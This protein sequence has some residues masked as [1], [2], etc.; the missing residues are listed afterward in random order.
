MADKIPFAPVGTSGST[1]STTGKTGKVAF[2][3][4][5]GVAP[6]TKPK[7]ATTPETPQIMNFAKTFF[8]AINTGGAFLEGFLNQSIKNVGDLYSGKAKISIDPVTGGVNFTGQKDPFTAGAQNATAWVRGEESKYG[9]DILKTAYEAK[10]TPVDLGKATTVD[11]P[12]LGPVSLGGLGLDI[13]L[14]P[15]NLI[16]G[17]VFTTPLKAATVGAK[18]LVKEAKLAKAGQLSEAVATKAGTKVVE[19]TAPQLLKPGASPIEQFTKKPLI[20][21]KNIRPEG[22]LA[23]RLAKTEKTIVEG[24][25]VLGKQ[26]PSILYKTVQ[27]AE[28]VPLSQAIASGLE[29]SAKAAKTVVLGELANASLSAL[30]KGERKAATVATRALINGE[31]KDLQPFEPHIAP[32]AT[33]VFDEM[34]V[35]HKFTNLDEATAWVKTQKQVGEKVNSTVGGV[36]VIDTGA[37]A[38]TPQIMARL[39]KN[40]EEAKAAQKSLTLID[41]IASKATG[42]AKN[43]VERTYSGFNDFIAGLSAGD[44][45]DYAVLEKIIKVLDPENKLVNKLEKAANTKNSYKL[46]KEALIAE[47]PQTV[48]DTQRRID[49]VN[50]NT[51]LKATG[52][53]EADTAAAYAQ[54]R[55]DGTS[56][57]SDIALSQS[58]NQAQINLTELGKRDPEALRGALYSINRGFDRVLARADEILRSPDMVAE[59]TNQGKLA[60]LSKDSRYAADQKA[61]LIKEFNQSGE[62]QV[63]STL[64][65]ILRKRTPNGQIDVN[66]FISLSGAINDALLG[67][68]GIRTVYSK[69]EAIAKGIPHFIYLSMHDFALVLQNAG[70]EKVLKK[71][72]FPDTLQAGILKTDAF[73]PISIGQ[74]IRKILEHKE[75]NIPLDVN[76]IISDLQRKGPGQEA[77]SETYKAQAP[78]IAKALAGVLTSPKIIA[79]FQRIHMTRAL[80]AVEDSITS[81]ETLSESLFMTLLDGWR[82]NLAKGVDTL[83]ARDQLVR[84]LFNEFVYTAGIFKQQNSDVAQATFQAAA[85]MFLNGG[86]LRDL[87]DPT[88]FTEL[89]PTGADAASR[90][91]YADMVESINSFFKQQNSSQYAAAGREKLPFHAADDVRQTAVSRLTAAKAAY[92]ELVIEGA[93]LTT[94][95]ELKSWRKQFAAAQKDL[96]AARQNAWKYSIPTHHWMDGQWVPSETYSRKAALKQAKDTGKDIVRTPAQVLDRT[97]DAI[98]T[99]AKFPSHKKMTLAESEAWLKNWRNENNVRGIDAQEG[100]RQEA[101]HDILNSQEHYA[102]LNLDPLELAQRMV[103][104]ETALALDGIKIPVLEGAAEYKPRSLKALGERL[105]AATGRWDLVGLL[106]KAQSNILTNSADVADFAHS[107]R[108]TYIKEWKNLVKTDAWR[109]AN[110]PASATRKEAAAIALEQRTKMFKKAFGHAINRT[111]PVGEDAFVAGLTAHL[112]S[113]FDTLFGNPENAAIT[114]HG[115]DP[116]MLSSAFNKFG[117]G[118]KIGFVAP[119]NLNPSQLADYL[120]WLP[121]GEIPEGLGD[122]ERAIWIGRAD[123]FA[124]TGED[125]FILVT[126]L[127]QAIQFARSEKG[128]VHD[129]ATQFGYKAQGLTFKQA[130]QDGWVQIKGVSMAGTNLADHLPL[131]QEGGLFPPHIAEQFLSVNR[132]WNKLYNSPGMPKILNNIMNIQGFFKATQTIFTARHHITNA[133]GDTT[134]ALI[135]GARNPVHWAQA[136]RMALSFAGEDAMSQWFNPAQLARAAKTVAT[137]ASSQGFAGARSAAAKQLRE[138]RLAYK[139]VQMFKGNEGYGR[140]VGTAKDGDPFSIEPAITVYKNGKTIKL[141]LDRETLLSEFKARG[142]AVGNIFANDIQGLSD[143]VLADVGTVGERKTLLKTIGAKINEGWRAIEKPAGSFASYYG[144]IP[145]IATAL[146]E[147]Q[148]RSWSS[149]EQALDAASKKVSTYHPTIQSLSASERRYPRMMF[150]YYTWLR[151]AH[152]AFIDMALNHTGAMLVPSKIQYAQAEAAGLEPTN[153][154]DPWSNELK[155]KLP[156]YLTG[157]VY[158]P[159]SVTDAGPMMFKRSIL[160]L[161]VLDTW[162]FSYDPAYSVDANMFNFQRSGPNSPIKTL[163]KTLVKNLNMPIQAVLEPALGINTSTGAPT[164]IKDYSTWLDSQLNKFGATSLLKGM[165]VIPSLKPLTPEE[166]QLKIENFWGGQKGQIL[167]T[168]QNLKNAVKEQNLRKR[169]SLAEESFSEFLKKYKE[170]LK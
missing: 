53:G 126:R 103:Q 112:R 118:S 30:A 104:D 133:V 101:A 106:N 110:I 102:A 117:L 151:V 61:Q 85:M 72:Y 93:P 105:N 40:A 134:T 78:T 135:G 99:V 157:S 145:R 82:A 57:A 84:D 73:S 8:Q 152:N 6:T 52:L 77:W 10:I 140:V 69:A 81:S 29:A 90:Q 51:T 15:T 17:K 109:A 62:V 129:F 68:A 74:S 107:L 89:V 18:A 119:G 34:G 167:E 65:G 49:M 45:V 161:D 64:T 98:D 146:N 46:L 63:L 37:K 142:I 76:E 148:S 36:P 44:Q 122:A 92:R 116:K 143:S 169:G 23:E 39:P 24:P 27:A 144:N 132:E 55:L 141:T 86:K 128:I 1:A 154:G 31:F 26:M 7:A 35:G 131:P 115:I 108:N 28:N 156:S 95:A 155:T 71:A 13:A 130:V 47:G 43:K 67:G 21:A 121:F 168:T 123:T 111:E 14:D 32:D 91:A 136:L 22:P 163:S 33:Y 12:L 50:V 160:P 75:R 139:F 83:A 138:E 170:S 56:Q 137:D 5:S 96:D 149:L 58:R 48:Y 59:A 25:K 38:I 11:V 88:K 153:I 113:M 147:M 158:G 162:S 87:V 97:G 80:A 2:A 124:Q 120:K 79:E 41:N 100:L 60:I 70:F 159:T 114:K 3:P 127:A 4:T 166:K 20:E 16:P 19:G 42:V 94:D 150:M 54:S 164:Q 125:P 9:T 66:E 165:G